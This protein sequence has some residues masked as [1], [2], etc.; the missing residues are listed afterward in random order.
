[1]GSKKGASDVKIH[2]WFKSVSWALLRHQTPPIVPK[3]QSPEDTFYFRNMRDSESDDKFDLEQIE[4]DQE[5]VDPFEDF[6]SGILILFKFI[7]SIIHND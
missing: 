5:N 1:M 3:L 2:P 7:V 6:E 4:E